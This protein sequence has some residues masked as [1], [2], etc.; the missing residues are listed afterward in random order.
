MGRKWLMIM[1]YYIDTNGYRTNS[2]NIFGYISCRIQ[3]FKNC[4]T[5]FEVYLSFDVEILLLVHRLPAKDNPGCTEEVGVSTVRWLEIGIDRVHRDLRDQLLLAEQSKTMLGGSKS[6]S[7]WQ[8]AGGVANRVPST[9]RYHSLRENLG[10][11]HLSISGT[12][13][14]DW[15]QSAV[16]HEET[17]VLGRSQGTV[18]IVVYWFY[19]HAKDD[20]PAPDGRNP[21][22][23]LLRLC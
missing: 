21:Y 4:W 17:S 11:L 5:I 10:H 6:M 15:Q 23:C 20:I 19:T 13:S 14:K 7:A 8:V 3:C 2:G 18:L 9:T 22:L 16:F 1:S 12:A